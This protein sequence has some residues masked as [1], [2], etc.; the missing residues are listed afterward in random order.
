MLFLNQIKRSAF[1][2]NPH[3]AQS[4][5]R[6]FHISNPQKQACYEQ[7]G[8]HFILGY[9]SLIQENNFES[10]LQRCPAELR[11]FFL[12]GA[13]MAG[14]ILASFPLPGVARFSN[15][16]FQKYSEDFGYLLHVGYGFAFARLPWLRW[17]PRQL[18]K[19]D[20]VLKFLAL[21][22][23]GFHAGFFNW[24]QSL[25]QEKRRSILK[26]YQRNA[27]DQG[28]GRSLLFIAGGDVPT[29]LELV[30]KFDPT[31]R[32]DIWGGLGLAVAYAGGLQKRELASLLFRSGI[33][34]PNLAQ[35]VCFGA[36]ARARANLIPQHTFLACQIICRATVEDVVELTREVRDGLD[37][38]NPLAYSVWRK[39]VS[40]HFVN[41]TSQIQRVSA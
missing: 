16:L 11:G 4:V 24:R 2:I 27:F 21:D 34:S 37:E 12:E 15:C 29:L 36:E 1:S 13:S 23:Y 8:Q 35:G 25:L 18:A 9:N 38:S 17:S 31:R 26:G 20:P 33:Y 30:S 41:N 14:K 5:R 6:G 40:R 19:L 10:N 22:G 3:E 7:I 28:L 39:S 32:E